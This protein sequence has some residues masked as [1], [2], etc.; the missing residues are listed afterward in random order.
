M[1]TTF[2]RIRTRAAMSISIEDKLKLQK[3]K[4]RRKLAYLTRQTLEDDLSDIEFGM[5]EYWV[6]R[7]SNKIF[8]TYKVIYHRQRVKTAQSFKNLGWQ[9]LVL[10]SWDLVIIY[11][12][13]K[14]KKKE[15]Y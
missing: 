6:L 8:R 9:M 14:E 7:S 10:S 3:P 12:K 2:F 1:Y 13:K 5:V 11:K 15:E 4:G